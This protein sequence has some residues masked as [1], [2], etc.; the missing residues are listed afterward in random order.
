M[1]ELFDAVLFDRDGTLVVDV[2]YNG[3]PS[4]VEPMP[5]AREAV[6]RLRAAGLRLGVITN[7]SGL[8]RGRFTADQLAAVN[9]RVD[10]IFGGFDT[11]QICPHDDT[12]GCDCR[13][14]APGLV[15]AAA[16][17]LDTTPARCV[18]VGD[19][20]RDMG[21]ALA[22]GAAGVLVPTPVTLPPEIAAAP[23]VA[24]TL[25]GAADLIL[26]REA[27]VTPAPR[28]APAGTTSAPAATTPTRGAVTPT[29]GAATPRPG[30]AGSALTGIVPVPRGVAAGTVLVVRADSAGDVL[31]TG[32]AIRAVAHGA[33]R[34]VMLCGPRGRGAAELLP[35]V[36]EIV[37]W[38][39]PWIDAE[40]GAVDAEEMAALT[41]RL[42]EVGADEAVVFT[43]FHQ[44][45]LP[46]ALLLRIAGVGRITA[47][48]DDYPG[49]LLDVR[50][51][52][53]AGIPEAERARSV[54]AAAGFGLPPGDDGS[55]RVTGVRHEGGGEYVVVHPGASCEARSCP[56]ETMR[57]I[58][59]ALAAGGHRVLVTGGDGER[60]LA[61]YVNG[62]VGV[63][64][65]R[66]SLTEMAEI[67]A[68]ASCLVVGNTGPAHLAAAVGTPVV[69]LYAPTVP[70]GQWGPYR[71]PNVRLGDAGAP[72]R[73]SRATVCPIAGHPCL[74]DIEP[75]RVVAAV[76][77][78]AAGAHERTEVAA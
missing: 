71:V 58:V 6:D 9:R 5:G 22:A 3:D 44:S 1:T 47:I 67:L 77:L 55:L 73:D 78:L 29:P 65:G 39:L 60:A 40:P 49:S 27:L 20:G 57:R 53:P 43:S 51:R 64:V 41:E 37:E 61:A 10:E 45:A 59:A 31:V 8:A 69:S 38:R 23:A 63:E 26:R 66:T 74:S 33:R 56:P 13:K 19:I 36:D 15:I 48:S 32:P 70:Y 68:R 28:P 16:E 2:P 62:G 50:H 17:A 72:C 42:R 7:Q 52:V 24:S 30:G 76:R 35:G 21:A 14:P 75:E 4:L 46:L 12:A 25:T 34:V 54:A 11:W 18:V